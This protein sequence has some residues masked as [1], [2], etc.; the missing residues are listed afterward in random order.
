MSD[1]VDPLKTCVHLRCKGMF[2]K[3]E[4]SQE[5]PEEEK[6]YGHCDTAVYWCDCTQTGRGPDE[7]R[8][9]LKACSEADRS[10]FKGVQSSTV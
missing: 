2:Y 8:V 4:V 7:K 1:S 6:H 3:S 9:N 5:K 10:C